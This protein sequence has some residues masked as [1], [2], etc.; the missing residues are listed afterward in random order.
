MSELINAP[1]RLVYRTAHLAL[2][3]YWLVRKPETHG[4]LVALWHEE[5]VLLIQSSYRRTL[6]LPGGYVKRGEDPKDAA[7][8]ELREELELDL[9]PE[10]LRHAWHGSLPFENRT[11]TLDIF[12]ADVMRPF[13]VAVNHRELIWSGWKTAYEARNERIVPHLR[14]YLEE[15]EARAK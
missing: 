3:A 7:R 11:D 6:S 2:R 5:K 8:R 14:A 13:H 12:E 15:R 10:K 4:A 1:A 9:P